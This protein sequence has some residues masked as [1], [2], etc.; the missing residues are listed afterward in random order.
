[1]AAKDNVDALTDNN[2]RCTKIEFLHTYP[3]LKVLV[4]PFISAPIALKQD[5][6]EWITEKYEK[7]RGFEIGTLNPSLLPS[8]FLEQSQNWGYFANEHIK[9][10]IQAIHRF[11]HEALR[12]CCKD[13]T[14]SKRL[15]AI[16]SQLL[17]SRY[18]RAL[19][20]VKFL[21]EV[22]QQGNLLTM[23]HYFAD[24]LRQARE[25]RIKKQLI[26]LQSWTT[27]N[28]QNQHLL[29]LEDTV[30][31]FLSNEGQTT[32]DLHD[33]LQAYYKV[34]R[35]RF[36]DAICLQA[37]DHFLISSKEG[38]LWLFSPQL[39]GNMTDS[40][41]RKI[42]GESDQTITRRDRLREEIANLNAGQKILE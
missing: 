33:I 26:N 10:V 35:K 9:N 25:D 37:V 41:L 38:P 21:I 4:S 18:K 28:S 7:S 11:N 31:A 29:R 3:E 32:Q 13:D 15:W 40:E 30:S 34:S 39:I 22:E 27:N 19:E 6:M 14:L 17:L 8:L 24:N 20:H 5:V 36:V 23:N 2:N 12:Y 1:M 16:L 42:A